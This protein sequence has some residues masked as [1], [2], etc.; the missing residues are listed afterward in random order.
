M[1]AP[2][3]AVLIYRVLNPWDYE[4]LLDNMEALDPVV[5]YM[6]WALRRQLGE[7]DIEWEVL[8]TVHGV[9]D[10]EL[11]ETWPLLSAYVCAQ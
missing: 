7:V 9:L 8:W 5:S 10:A 3:K 2:D 11:S 6:E 1:A 4:Y